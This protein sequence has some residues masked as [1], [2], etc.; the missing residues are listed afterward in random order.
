[1]TVA[2]MDNLERYRR[3]QAQ[4][5]AALKRLGVDNV[6]CPLCGE[7]DPLC[8]EADHHDRRANSNLVIGLCKNCHAKVTARQLSEH[9]PVS[10]KPNPGERRK[11]ALLGAAVYLEL[12]AK[13][14]RSIGEADD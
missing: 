12:I 7:D 1:V 6:E 13:R 3:R 4:R 11:H 5:W 8:F 2:A 14:F 10:L 9:P